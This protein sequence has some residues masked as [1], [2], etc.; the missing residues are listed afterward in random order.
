MEQEKKK[1]PMDG[2]KLF[3]ILYFVI[4]MLILT[5]IGFMSWLGYA[6]VDPSIQYMLF[7]LLLGSALIG[8]ALWLVR[9][10]SN[11]GIKLVFGAAS[12]IFIIVLLAVMYIAF[13]LL[14]KVATPLHYTTLTSPEGENVVIMRIYSNDAALLSERMQANGKDPSADPEEQDLG[15]LYSAHP[16]KLRFFYDAQVSGEGSVEIG[17]S[18]QAQ[19]MYEWLPDGQLHLFIDVPEAGD[20][21]EIFFTP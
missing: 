8:G 14:L 10:I 2:R 18:S 12:T 13:S 5:F 11:K 20:T 19:L 4:L 16:R 9:R 3:F 15:Y 17:V 6:L 7:G 1:S 21:G